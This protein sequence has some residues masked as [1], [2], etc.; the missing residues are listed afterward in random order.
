[1]TA[2][3]KA[4]S[5]IVDVLMALPTATCID[6]AVELAEDSSST[7]QSIGTAVLG[8]RPAATLARSL[9]AEWLIGDLEDV[10][11]RLGV[12]EPWLTISEALEAV[13]AAERA[14]HPTWR[15]A[16][17]RRARATGLEGGRVMTN[18]KEP[19]T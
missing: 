14:A 1:M 17:D 7:L 13:I 4:A 18:R 19:P 16:H 10:A 3:E 12:S 11:P 9:H 5:A 15:T 6:L 8:R 2:V